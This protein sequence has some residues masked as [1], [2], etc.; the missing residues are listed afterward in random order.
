MAS[1]ADIAAALRLINTPTVGPKKF[2]RLVEEQESVDG[3]LALLERESIYKP[4]TLER[5]LQEIG[6]AEALGVQILLYT[7]EAY[8]KMLSGNTNMPPVL[9]AKGR[10]DILQTGKSLAIVGSRA[11][12]INGRKT[13][14]HIAKDLTESGVMIVSGMARG[15]D[16]AAHK[17]ALYANGETGA[18]IAVLGTGLDVI[19]PP[20]NTDLYH[21]IEQQGCLLS[22]VPLGTQANALQFPRRNRIVAAL[23]EGVLVVEAGLKSGS[24]ITAQLAL[25]MKKILFAVPGT[26]GESRAQGS[27]HLIKKGA[28]L[29]ENADD[30]LPFL[31]GNAEPPAQ[32]KA[33]PKQKI[34]VFENKDV[35][36]SNQQKSTGTLA[37]FLTVDGI[38]IDELI[39][40]TGKDAASISL[41]ILDLEMSGLVE[42]RA[43]NKIALI[44]QD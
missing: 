25:N 27:N 28:V 19:Y 12:S 18:T 23:S 31:K 30:I 5:A 29:V 9:Y 40:L 20:E 36:L 4:W 24:L 43:G 14:A 39:R 34:L 41:E 10:I 11:A 37:D 6:K 8:P 26:P 22:E 33:L 35:K 38:E 7:D 42:R 15:I 13:A 21:Q 17:G 3:A 16:A 2:Y 1:R 44:E 32:Q